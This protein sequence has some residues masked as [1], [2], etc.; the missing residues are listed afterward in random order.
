MEHDYT[1]VYLL[2]SDRLLLGLTCL[3]EH[4]HPWNFNNVRILSCGV[5]RPIRAD[6]NFSAEHYL[7]II[8]ASMPI[9]KPLFSKLLDSTELGSSRNSSR[10]SFQKIR[11]SGAAERGPE[12]HAPSDRSSMGA[13]YIK[14]TTDIRISSH[15]EFEVNRDYDL[16]SG[17]LPDH[18]RY[19]G[20]SWARENGVGEEHTTRA[21]AGGRRHNNDDALRPTSVP[22]VP[23]G[24]P[25]ARIQP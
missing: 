19:S 20:N 7:G 18:L 5:Q 10:R 12:S 1:C 14:R 4:R 6:G 9:L 13:D 3:R 21:P 23:K 25:P 8:I 15:L 22:L 16:Y 11:S 17:P 2:R 24:L